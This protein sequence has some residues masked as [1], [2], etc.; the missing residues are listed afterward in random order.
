MQARAV[1]IHQRKLARRG[2]IEDDE[3]IVDSIPILTTQQRTTKDPYRQRASG[4]RLVQTFPKSVH[5]SAKSAVREIFCRLFCIKYM[6]TFCRLLC[7][8]L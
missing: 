2:I 1:R 7:R 5:E 3:D 6:Q 4:G 8:F